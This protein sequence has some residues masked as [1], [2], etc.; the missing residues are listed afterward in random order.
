M[1]RIIQVEFMSRRIAACSTKIDRHFPGTHCIVPALDLAGGIVRRAA[2]ACVAAE[3]D[4]YYKC[5]YP[6]RGLSFHRTTLL[7]HA[8][9]SALITEPVKPRSSSSN[10]SLLLNQL[11]RGPRCPRELPVDAGAFGQSLYSPFICSRRRLVMIT[12]NKEEN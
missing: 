3:A 12:S 5:Q 1:R 8:L 7:I 11:R 9:H 10:T 2:L 4:Y 6:S